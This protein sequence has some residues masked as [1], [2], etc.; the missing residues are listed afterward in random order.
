MNPRRRGPD[1]PREAL[2]RAGRAR[3][4]RGSVV[5]LVAVLLAGALVGV[6]ALGAVAGAAVAARHARTAADLAALAGARAWL[7]SGS[8]CA[9]AAAHAKLNGGRLTSCAAEPSGQITVVVEVGLW[10]PWSGRSR[11]ARAEARAGPAP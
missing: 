3:A 8:P 1:S 2:P 7:E 10:L 9:V 11:S 4:E 6:V 5:P